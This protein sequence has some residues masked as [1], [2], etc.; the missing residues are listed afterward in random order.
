MYNFENAKF[1]ITVDNY[2]DLPQSQGEVAFV[3]RSNCGKSSLINSLTNQKKLAFT[4]KTPGRTQHIN[5]FDFNENLFL[6]DLPGYGYAKVSESKKKHWEEL[7]NKYFEARKELLGMILIMDIRHPLKDL[8]FKMIDFFKYS[9]KPIHIVLN[10]SD[11]LS[12]EKQKASYNKVKDVLFKQYSNISIQ[13]FSS[14]KK[15]GVIELKETLNTF[16]I[17]H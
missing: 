15:T 17:K 16:F 5:F 11:K 13:L 10:K 2:K 1:F 9:K 14:L 6:V 12:R 7:L 3:G 8:D 4:S